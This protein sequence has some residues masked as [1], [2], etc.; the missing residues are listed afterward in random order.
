[1]I[2]RTMGKYSY[3]KIIK[4]TRTL[5]S[6]CMIAIGFSVI[7]HH[8]QVHNET[9]YL[10][11]FILIMILAGIAISSIDIPI[12]YMLQQTISDDFRGRVLS[13]GISIA[14]IILP[15]ALIIAGV[16]INLI[17]PYILPI[18]SGIGLCIFSMFYIKID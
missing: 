4:L 1:M 9:V 16:L 14:K 7:L 13:I 18:I 11:Y 10:I 17:L 15:V 6:A 8:Y 2:K 3:K 5:L 12:L